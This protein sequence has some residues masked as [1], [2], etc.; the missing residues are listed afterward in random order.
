MLKAWEK[1]RNR[2][3]INQLSKVFVLLLK[4]VY[5][6]IKTKREK[7]TLKM[8]TNEQKRDVTY[9]VFSLEETANP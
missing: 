8:F 2:Y 1:E 4:F 5:P 6:M 3:N 9:I 7:K